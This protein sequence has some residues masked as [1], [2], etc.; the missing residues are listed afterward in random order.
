M[1][2][3][4]SHQFQFEELW[5]SLLKPSKES[6]ML[7]KKQLRSYFRLSK[8]PNEYQAAYDFCFKRTEK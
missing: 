8:I 4:F 5:N 2:V 7:K 6:G 3:S 1:S